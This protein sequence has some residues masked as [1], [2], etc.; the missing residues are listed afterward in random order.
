MFTFLLMIVKFSSCYTMLWFYL[1]SSYPIQYI[2]GT[3]HSQRSFNY[4]LWK[5]NVPLP[6]FMFSS[7]ILDIS[8]IVIFYCLFCALWVHLLLFVG[9]SESLSQ[10]LMLLV[11]LWCLR[12][13]V[14]RYVLVV[15]MVVL[16]WTM[17]W[18]LLDKGVH[19]C[20]WFIN[21]L[22]FPSPKIL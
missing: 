1:S 8:Q 12:Y 4:G 17:K 5:R 18:F 3:F 6:G 7:L 19:F 10:A 21:E 13:S 9:N 16:F 15:N 22:N 14:S 2:Y 11:H 20:K